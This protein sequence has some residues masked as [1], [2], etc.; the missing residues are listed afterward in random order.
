MPGRLTRK[1]S[2]FLI[3]A[4]HSKAMIGRHHQLISTR[5]PRMGSDGPGGVAD[6][7]GTDFNPRSPYGERRRAE[8]RSGCRP[9]STHAPRMGSDNI[10]F[11]SRQLRLISTHAPRMGSD[12]WVQESTR[13]FRTISTHAPR[14]GSDGLYNESETGTSHF[15][16]RSPYG[17]RRGFAMITSVG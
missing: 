6:A 5:A 16:P 8:P 9:I 1:T 13:R 4:P 15:N 3:H 14:M 7:H 12:L 10:C 2:E 11:T 17:E